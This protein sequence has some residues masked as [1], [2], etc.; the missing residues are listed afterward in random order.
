ME[1][2]WPAA[3]RRP[4]R[5]GSALLLALLLAGCG[6][7]DAPASSAAGKRRFDS[8]GGRYAVELETKP[9]AIAVNQPFDVHVKVSPKGGPAAD[10]DVVVDA[11]MPAHFHGMNRVARMVRGEGGSWKAEGLVFHM[12]GHWELYVDVTQGGRTERAQMDVDLK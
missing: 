1:I 8:N 12:S 4:S 5:S 6:G 11:R 7:S 10:L 9:A 2:T 3:W